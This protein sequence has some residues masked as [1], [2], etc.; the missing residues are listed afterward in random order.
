MRQRII[1][2]FEAWWAHHGD[3]LI[4]ANDLHPDVLELIDTKAKR[5]DGEISINRQWVAGYLRAKIGTRVGGFL[6]SQVKDTSRTRPI[7]FYK[8]QQT[9]EP[10]P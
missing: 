2:V 3:I 9:K 6:L 8:L 7:A 1:D 5:K 4:K 10:M